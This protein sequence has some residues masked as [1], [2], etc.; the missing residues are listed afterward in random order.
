[1]ALD[2]SKI[3]AHALQDVRKRGYSDDD[4]RAMTAREFFSEYCNWNGLMRWGD[5]LFSVVEASQKA[6]K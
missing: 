5:T 2:L 6:S 4:I 1:M 3:P